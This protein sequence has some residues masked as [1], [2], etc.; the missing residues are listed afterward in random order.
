MADA[1]A[2]VSRLDL[3]RRQEDEI[4]DLKAENATLRAERDAAFAMSKCECG[5]DEACANL[6]RLRADMAEIRKATIEEAAKVAEG[7]APRSFDSSAI[8]AA[9]RNMGEKL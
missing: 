8:A 3:V 6:A 4:R 9:I 7:Y 2:H 5:A 1:D